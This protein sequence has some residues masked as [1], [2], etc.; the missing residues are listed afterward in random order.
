[1]K[2]S[3]FAVLVLGVLLISQIEALKNEAIKYPLYDKIGS[4]EI[5]KQGLAEKIVKAKIKS[6]LKKFK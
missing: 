3:S 6:E 2:T 1:M 5:A 4:V